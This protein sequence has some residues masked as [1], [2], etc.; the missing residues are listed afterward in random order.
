MAKF[1]VYQIKLT[2]DQ[3]NLINE[4][5]DFNAVPAFAAQNAM[6]LDFRGEKIG[7]LADNAFEAGYYTHVA[8]VEAANYNECFEV[9]NIGPESSIERLSTF[10]M[11]SLSV[12][13][14]LVHEDGTQVV[15]ASMGF[16]AIGHKPQLCA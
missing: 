10:Q 4:T 6:M 11:S 16:V 8:N 9:G 5:G 14:I 3:R 12:G 1:A 15:V 2:K 7:G 13:D